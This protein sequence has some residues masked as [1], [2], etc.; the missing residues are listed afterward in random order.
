MISMGEGRLAMVKKNLKSTSSLVCLDMVSSRMAVEST[1]LC[2][3]CLLDPPQEI[4]KIKRP[5]KEITD[6][7]RFN[8]T[9]EFDAN[10]KSLN[11]YQ[12][13]QLMRKLFQVFK[14]KSNPVNH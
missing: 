7:V 9:I 1:P 5:Y 6:S 3:A 4:R 10:I 8:I 11:F 13:T 2:S 12:R 14:D